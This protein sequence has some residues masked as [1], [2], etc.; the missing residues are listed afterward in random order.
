MGVHAMFRNLSGERLQ[1]DAPA[2][3]SGRL[4]YAVAIAA[5]TMPWLVAGALTGNALV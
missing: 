3:A 2:E 5:G 4:P 1:F